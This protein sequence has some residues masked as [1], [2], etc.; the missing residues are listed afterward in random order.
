MAI[1]ARC[2]KEQTPDR[3]VYSTFT[4]SHYCADFTACDRRRA[5]RG[6]L[7]VAPCDETA[8]ADVWGTPAAVSSQGAPSR[9]QPI[10]YQG[11]SFGDASQGAPA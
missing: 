11:P 6:K 5:R 1:C 10:P 9:S 7:K 2:V 3:M 4:R 8:T